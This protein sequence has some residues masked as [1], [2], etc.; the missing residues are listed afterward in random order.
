MIDKYLTQLRRI[1]RKNQIDYN[2][3]PKPVRT[4][5]FS[6]VVHTWNI[7]PGEI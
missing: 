6:R 1:C 3:L 5:L 7:K 2:S 4:I